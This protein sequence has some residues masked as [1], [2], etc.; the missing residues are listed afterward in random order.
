LNASRT[1]SAA[2]RTAGPLFASFIFLLTALMPS[3][4]APQRSGAGQFLALSAALRA[5]HTR[6]AAPVNPNATGDQHTPNGRV[7]LDRRMMRSNAIRKPR[8]G[9]GSNT[10]P[11]PGAVQTFDVFN[12]P[13]AFR[14][15]VG[16]AGA[17]GLTN[18]AANPPVFTGALTATNLTPVWSAD[19]TFLLFSSNRTQMG[20]VNADGP[21]GTPLF[22]LWVISV[23]G[24]EAFQ[25]TTSSTGTGEFFPTL[26]STNN[27]L[28]FVS[29][30]QSPGTRNLY[31]A[32]G[33]AAGSFLNAART[34][35]DVSQ[36]DVTK[37]GITSVTMRGLDP[38]G[39]SATG[40]TQVNRPTFAPGNPGQLA[41][42]AFSITG[43]NRGRNHIYFLNTITGGF[44]P[45]NISFPAKLTDGPADDT[46]PAW[47]QD[48]QFI[49]FASTAGTFANQPNGS[50]SFGPTPPSGEQDPN[51]S[52]VISSTPDTQGRRSIFFINGGGGNV[53]GN[54]AGFGQLPVSLQSVGG[55]ITAVGTDD[56]GP[57]WSNTTIRNQYTNPA[58]GF[59]YL[60]FGRGATPAS[61]HD[62]YY[63]QVVR[64][65]DAGG[66]T[67][68]STEAGTTPETIAT[69][70]YQIDAG[71]PF[72][73]N[74][75]YGPDTAFATGGAT[76]N[77]PGPFNTT[78]DP[79]TPQGIYSTDRNGTAFSY[80]FPSLTPNATYTVRLHLLDPSPTA[81]P[82]TRVFSVSEN[83]RPVTEIDNVFDAQGRPIGFDIAK[84]TGTAPGQ[85][86][87]LVSANGAP[88][89]GATV[90][91]TPSSGAAP[92]TVTTTAAATTNYTA[93]VSAG[94]ATET[95]SAPG[96]GTQTVRISVNSN[97]STRSDF[98]LVPNNATLSGSVRD[99]NGPIGGVTVTV[100][101]QNTNAIVATTT[102]AANGTFANVPV[103]AGTYNVT[104]QPAV[105]RA[106]T[107]TL[108]AT[109]TAGQ[110]TAVNFVLQSGTTTGVLGGL[111]TD[112]A[113]VPLTGATVTITGP[114]NYLAVVTTT[115]VT[116]PAAGPTG[117]KNP[118]NF[119]VAL[120]GAATPGLTYSITPSLTGTNVSQ[121]NTQ[122]VINGQFNRD[123]T[124]VLTRTNGS[125][126]GNTATVQTFTTTIPRQSFTNPNNGIAVTAGTV[127]LNF[128]GVTGNAIVEGIE[129]IANTTD[130]TQS[131][132]F[133]GFSDNSDPSGPGQLAALGGDG[134]VVLTF[135]A[136][137]NTQAEPPA[138]YNIF[139]SPA[140]PTSVNNP[141]A[142]SGGAGQ[143]G[144]VPFLTNVQ[145]TNNGN[146][147]L[148]FVDTAVT[149]GNEYFYQVTA[150]LQQRIT[151]EGAQPGRPNAPNNVAIKL[152]TDDNAGQTSTTGNA[153]DDVYP[154]W[155]PFLSIFSIAYQSGN[156]Q[157]NAVVGGRTVT[158][159]NP[160]TS[161]PTE[162]AVSVG[163]GGTVATSDTNAPA[164][165]VG[166]GYTGIFESQVLNLDP[167]TL[168]RF[169]NNEIVHVQSAGP[170]PV[171]GT[172]NK[173]AATGGQAVTFTV[174]LSDR[175]AG[176]DNTGGPN[177]GPRVYIQIKDPD[178]K[179]QD[180]QALE[181]KVFSHDPQ[182]IRQSNRAATG[183]TG[184]ASA[185]GS[186]GLAFADFE[187]QNTPNFPFQRFTYPSYGKPATGS[188]DIA[189][190]V[191]PRGAHGGQWP[192]PNG[193]NPDNT[194]IFV[195]KDGGG[196][197]PVTGLQGG[198][199]NLFIPTGPEYETQ[200]L[201]PQF[202][203]SGNQLAP[204]DASPNDYRNPFYLA[205]VDDQQAFSGG[206]YP[207]GTDRPTANVVT[208][209]GTTP[210]E[211]LQLQPVPQAQQDNLGGVLYT[212]TFT[213]PMSVSDF[214]LDVIAYDKARF[215]NFPS[216]TSRYSGGRTNW[217]IYDNVGGFSTQRDIGSNDI[218]FVSDYA[219]GQK[220]AAT[221]FAGQQANLNL[222]PKLFGTES[223]LTD[224]DV[225][226]LPDRV[227]AGIPTSATSYFFNAVLDPFNYLG[228]GSPVP[229]QFP[230]QNGLGVGSYTDS[231]ISTGTRDGT[232]FDTSQKYSLWR[233]LSRGPVPQ[234]ILNAYAPTR[235]QQP[236][237]Q[238][239]QSDI[240]ALKNLPAATILSAPRCIV[241]LSPYTGDLLTDPGT[242][243][244][245]GSFN[246]PGQPDRSST[247]T[248][249][250]NYVASG[251]RLFITGQDVGSALTL[252]GTVGNAPSG[253][254]AKPNFLPDVLNAQLKSP[255]NGST[256]LNATANR[257]TGNPLYDGSRGGNNGGI[258]YLSADGTFGGNPGIGS[259]KF[260]YPY[261]DHLELSD[262]DRNDAAFS[263]VPS[264]QLPTGASIQGQIDTVT[265]TNGATTAITYTNGDAALVYHD[266]TFDVN[267]PHTLP[268]GGTGSRVAYAA[269]GLEAMSS[270]F[271][272]NDAPNPSATPPYDL[273]IPPVF[274]RNVRQA[275]LHNVVCYLRTGS[276]S[277]SI[278]QTAGTGQ[279]AGQ[280]VQGV[281]V[282]LHPTNG[283]TPP[284]RASF[285][286][287][288]DGGGNYTIAGVEPG[289]Y[290]LVAYKAGFTRAVSNAGI[291]F[292]VEGDVNVQGGTL[293]VAPVP[294][295]NIA[296][297]V[298][299]KGG[300]PVIGAVATFT[301]V[302]KSIVKTVTTF[303]GKQA[304]QPAGTY[305]LPSVPVT[306]Y[307]GAA[308]GPLNDQ[309]LAEYMPAAAPDPP[310]DTGVVVQ[311]QTTTQPVNFTLIPNP[312][313]VSGHVF[314]TTQ[315][316]TAA[317]QAALAK[318]TV[319]A[320]APG[321][322]VAAATTTAGPDGSYT[323]S[324]PATQTQTTYTITAT[325][326]GYQMPPGAAP[327]TVMVV[328][329]DKFTGKDV[330]LMP[331][332]PGSIS[333][334]VT[335]NSN[336]AQP[337]AGATVTFTPQGGGTT[338]TA[339]SA[340][341]GTFSIANVPADTYTGTAV[342]PNNPNGK[343]T[344]T[345][346]PAQS[347]KV[348]PGAN[349]GPV[350]FVLVPV[351]PSVS[352][353]VTD[354]TTKAPL[355][356]V[357]VTT[358]DNTAGTSAVTTTG[359]D[360]T[361]NTGPLKPGDSYTLTF[362]L[363]GYMGA[364]LGPQTLNNGDALTG[365]NVALTPVPP[366]SITGSVTDG[367]GLPVVGATVTFTPDT[368]T[369]VRTAT[370]DGN[371]NYVIPPTGQDVPAGGYTATVVGPNNS[372]GK[373][374]YAAPVSKHI[375]VP[376]GNGKNPVVVNFTL[377]ALSPM[378]TGTVFDNTVAAH[379]G[380]GGATVT[381][382]PVSGTVVTVTANGSGVYSSGPL[383]PGTYAVTASAPGYFT[384]TGVPATVTVE[385]GDTSTGVNVPLSQKATIFGLI[386]DATTG[387]A[388]PGVTLT[389][390]DAATGAA[391]VTVPAPLTTTNP[392]TGTDGQP[393]NYLASLPPG[394]YVLSA[395]NPNYST[396]TSAPFTVGSAT[397]V[398]VDLKLLSSIGTLG[399][400]VTD[401]TSGT[402]VGGA[403][404]TV[405]AS[406]T[407]TVVATV[408]TSS[409]ASAA[410]DG[411]QLNYTV[412]LTKG[413]YTVTIQKGSQGPISQTVTIKGGVFNRLDFT[414]PTNGLPALHTFAAG[415]QFL[416]AP[417]D[418]STSTFDAIFGGLNTAPAGTTPNGNRS[419][420]AVWDPTA[421]GGVG[422][423]M[424]DPNPPA[425]AFRIGYGYWIYLKNSV[426][427]VQAG[428]VPGAGTVP[429]SLH[430]SWNQI[431]VASPNPAGTPVSSLL[432][433]NGAGG[434]ITFAQAVGSQYH[435]VSP[436][437]YQYTAGVYQ[438]ITQ[439]DVL[440]PYHAY[441]I[442]VF[443][444]ATLE[445]P[446]K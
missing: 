148:T 382:T 328:L 218:L 130:A 375:T 428:T 371:G 389:V 46:D 385:L 219:L 67:G 339:T 154:T 103:P 204:A 155:S 330:G 33:L 26:S 106:A 28:A 51:Q 71:N 414:G 216:G 311:S 435:L 25:V 367:A 129:V 236:A 43:N 206:V 220:F 319:S 209:N 187:H 205:G 86:L 332:P 121:G 411:G 179:Y 36:P 166:A 380:I 88:L 352:G 262:V 285:S 402:P 70:I 396:G 253:N 135:Q 403:T 212:V 114:N 310:F 50:N 327:I 119:Q 431:G 388:L 132:G 4:A 13:P 391:V 381:L 397:P 309:G 432:F 247:Q 364:T 99:Q 196:V 345:A 377:T 41:F 57:A 123:A 263:Q 276:I 429:V 141:G 261:L 387:A 90:T 151:P 195:G 235:I 308:T 246:I 298:K 362:A 16:F 313:T 393:Q 98:T 64:N 383:A 351:P 420:V 142:N 344:T 202:A 248:N 444:D 11:I 127:V 329:G 146:G 239:P 159:N 229:S 124:Q 440:L 307:T 109:F 105:G 152:N 29:D 118:Q 321:S 139:R 183:D 138:G 374:K 237:I 131:S 2:A 158:Y 280:G 18:S 300:S 394:T 194:Y 370:T 59:E 84:A 149:N 316:D 294:P 189:R 291:A 228:P 365:Q 430:P 185:D 401:A 175:E 101:D 315:G 226:I 358:T 297:T 406:A 257:I 306:T 97:G 354:A 353:T 250:A 357:Q 164:Y 283:A 150:I 416:S 386:S 193:N 282:Y 277:G 379:P 368:G 169:S 336:P 408:T 437:L 251:G 108:P 69:P 92:V 8:A 320:F 117:D 173:L 222:V 100:T 115:A 252:N 93:S 126:G 168:L 234:S 160:T 417:F 58:P 156:F 286:A 85:V 225:S 317:G 199:P 331:I 301:S 42:S 244:D 268:N 304:G 104:A 290:T 44:D 78:S 5:A 348:T 398:R 426:A 1:T 439:S 287:T 60:A 392:A 438:P 186:L 415:F 318:A 360:G 9:T 334:I 107:Q 53:S 215:P 273:T 384:G 184:S 192:F 80:L 303:D 217:R 200:V 3:F 15:L 122:P 165:S 73:G 295:G 369:A 24:G 434:T 366:G 322:T 413:T 359:A 22:H 208:A 133:G 270:D 390:S 89:A 441:W 412:S 210:A 410:P 305:F 72:G 356:G 19:Q 37:N 256:V 271:Y 140:E 128:T 221:T 14:P 77:N 425:D 292:T 213:T 423:Y 418:Y 111:I 275:I 238:D 63:L 95:V 174:R 333:G 350:T 137:P 343:P 346:A 289:T 191:F 265:P 116:S 433:D 112:A 254:P 323:L 30:A 167:P 190:F 241:W 188:P 400:L 231:V 214:Y 181:H 242:I 201:N 342:G 32:S 325:K 39:N 136:P 272:A 312:T 245:P 337:I 91:I 120:P 40:F 296:G 20:G 227:Y 203:T 341:D 260:Q 81:A 338:Q 278:N 249:L 171:T 409:T 31:V 48:G 224:V 211:W 157:G 259:I 442:K 293:T 355:A 264:I 79:G 446:I 162:T 38:F 274:P 361:Y 75:P 94:T 197:N 23:N 87:G 299:D 49:A 363:N 102:S 145:P 180:S 35:V 443:A 281:T 177:G 198:N 404:V 335:D 83:G 223:Y 427:L 182:F 314:D 113:G 176:I 395:S 207:N 144:S 54:S 65:I 232:T 134:Q 21:G 424:L 349:T 66:Q 172:P 61:P 147:Q 376:P 279:G 436:T 233:I 74:P 399:G 17:N 288:T 6:A 302:D 255:G 422:M 347:V 405:T 62:I 324:L 143:E 76:E 178:S 56:F 34:P 125:T 326:A 267:K 269:F 240:P 230:T 45:N 170:N 163:A 55:R 12:P 68:R 284:T 82:G 407:K 52:Q 340:A 153:Y 373:P 161:F 372:K 7:L 243:D 266:D 47:S 27:D 445:E 96:F 110:N 258:R 378:I 419:H 10:V 421:A